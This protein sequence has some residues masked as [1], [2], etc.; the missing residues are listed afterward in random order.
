MRK[1]LVISTMLFFST[2]SFSMADDFTSE[3]KADIRNLLEISGAL[4]MGKQ[5]SS[6]V[7][8]QMTQILKSTRP[9]IPDKMYEILEEE[10][11]LIIEE[12]MTAEGGLLELTIIIYHRYYS[13]EDVKGLLSFYKTAL[14]KKLIKTQPQV[15]Q[16]SIQAG[17]LWGQALGPLIQERLEARFENEGVDL[18]I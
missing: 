6:A 11:N 9:D 3:K 10:V 7:I 15:M 12:Q 4:D 14:G 5:M 13:H 16:E 18:S 1:I 8:Q 2:L 17:Q